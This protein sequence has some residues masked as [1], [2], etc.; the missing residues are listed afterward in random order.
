MLSLF[1]EETGNTEFKLLEA[2]KLLMLYHAVI[3]NI[4]MNQGKDV[5]VLAWLLFARDTSSDPCGLL[6]NHLNSVGDT[7]GLEQVR[8]RNFPLFVAPSPCTKNIRN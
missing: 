1:N 3:L 8:V 2:V 7:G 4:D 5:P 6:R